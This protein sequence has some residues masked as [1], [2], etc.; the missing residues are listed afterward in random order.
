M[1]VEY[2]ERPGIVQEVKKEIEYKLVARSVLRPGHSL[3]VFDPEKMTI[4]KVVLEV[5]LAYNTDTKT[6]TTRRKNKLEKGKQYVTA[7]NARNAA[8]KL[9]LKLNPRTA[10]KCAS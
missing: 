9:G 4:D 3:W 2:E 1:K 10:A 8:R 6:A 7:L 5:E